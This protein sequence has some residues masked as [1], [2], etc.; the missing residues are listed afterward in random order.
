MCEKILP[1]IPLSITL[2]VYISF[3][4]TFTI[5]Y[6]T[7]ETMYIYK[8]IC[9]VTLFLI[10]YSY[11]YSQNGVI[12]SE[13]ANATLNPSAIL[14]LQ[15]NNKGFLVPRLSLA[16]RNNINAVNGLTIYQT[17]NDPGFYL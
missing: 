10:V 2:E 4:T 11:S 13:D 16:Q 14:E 15:S 12:I 5:A 17:D 3:R 6:S 7:I 1:Y 8:K 9:L